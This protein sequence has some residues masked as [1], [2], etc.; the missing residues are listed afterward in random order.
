MTGCKLFLPGPM[1]DNASA[2]QKIV[3]MIVGGVG[4]SG[5]VVIELYNAQREMGTYRHIDAASD[6]SGKPVGAVR[7]ASLSASGMRCAQQNLGE[8]LGLMFSFQ[9]RLRNFVTCPC[10][11]RSEC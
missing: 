1:I 5:E 8:R 4:K 9:P 10:Q 7:E 6:A 3:L 2:H 11:I